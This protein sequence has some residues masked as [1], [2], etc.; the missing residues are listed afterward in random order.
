MKSA[1]TFN[2]TNLAY[3]TIARL[4]VS[5]SNNSASIP[6]PSRIKCLTIGVLSSQLPGVYSLK[7]RSNR[8][9]TLL[10]RQVS[11]LP[12]PSVRLNSGDDDVDKAGC[13][14]GTFILVLLSRPYVFR[15]AQQSAHRKPTA[16]TTPSLPVLFFQEQHQCRVV[17]LALQELP[18][19]TYY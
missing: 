1:T 18:L 16:R 12:P 13:L 4:S 17:C 2:L 7:S 8:R 15:V 3:S 9:A 5:P 10:V 14:I 6:T 19:T 11:K